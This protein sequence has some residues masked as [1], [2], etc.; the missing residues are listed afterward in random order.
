MSSRNPNSASAARTSSAF[1]ASQ[2]VKMRSSWR[3][4]D[5]VFNHRGDRPLLRRGLGKL[6]EPGRRPNRFEPHVRSERGRPD[7][8][9]N[10]PRFRCSRLGD[11][12]SL[13][14]VGAHSGGAG[15]AALPRAIGPRPRRAAQ[16]CLADTVLGL[17]P[18]TGC[19]LCL[20]RRRARGR[21]P[22][23]PSSSQRNVASTF[24]VFQANGYQFLEQLHGDDLA[25]CRQAFRSPARV[26]ASRLSSAGTDRFRTTGSTADGRKLP[27]L[28]PD[29]AEGPDSSPCSSRSQEIPAARTSNKAFVRTG[30]DR[31]EV[32]LRR[33][34][35]PAATQ[36]GSQVR[37][38]TSRARSR[39]T[40]GSGARSRSGTEKLSVTVGAVKA[41]VR[42]NR[43]DAQPARPGDLAEGLDGL[44]SVSPLRLHAPH[45]VI[46]QAP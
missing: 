33:E 34:D 25:R 22:P 18:G 29:S 28:S 26:S 3:S 30:P 42:G 1:S 14:L 11:L 41:V 20:D 32:A 10:H 5:Q 7:R 43:L 15:G 21:M 23:S 24:S 19:R 6:S 9:P 36:R 2:S 44:R 35:R 38:P 39:R 8:E 12:A 4:G 17:R 16:R 40:P 45:V 31:Q 13:R 46:I 37:L 27:K